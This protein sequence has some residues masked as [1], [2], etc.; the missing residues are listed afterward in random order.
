MDRFPS[1]YTQSPDSYGIVRR[2]EWGYQF[3][4]GFTSLC[5]DN[6]CRLNGDF[7]VSK[8]KTTINWYNKV[9]IITINNT[10]LFK[11]TLVGKMVSEPPKK[12]LKP[13]MIE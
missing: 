4:D 3:Y 10:S 8:D 6:G 1:K 9:L 2:G 11:K 13:S 5:G 12:T 7:L